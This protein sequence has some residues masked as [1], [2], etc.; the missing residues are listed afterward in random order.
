[1]NGL[2]AT[3]GG[4]PLAGRL[5]LLGAILV[6]TAPHLLRL[7]LWLSPLCLLLLGWR[8]GVELR[9][10]QLPGR[11]LRL[12]LTLL[13]IAAVVAGYRT[14]LGRDAGLALLT[15]MLCLKLLELRSQRDAM[16]ALSLGYFLVAGGFLYDQSLLVGA[17]LFFVVLILTAALVALNH[18]AGTLAHSRYYLRLGGS[19][20]LQALPIMLLLFVLFPRIPGPLWGLPKDAFAGKTGL[21]NHMTLDNITELADSDEVAFRVRFEGPMP[22]AAHLYWRGPVLWYTDGRRWDPLPNAPGN[23]WYRQVPTLQSLGTP[24]SYTVTQEPNNERWLFALDLPTQF[25]DGAW[26]SADYQLRLRRKLTS[27]QRYTLTSALQYRTGN[28]TAAER[29]A[30]LQLPPRVNPRSRELANEWRT[31]P[32]P[33][34]VQRALAY[35]RDQPFYYTRRPPP[36]GTNAMDDFLFSTRRGF[37][38]HYAAAFTML[39]RAAGVPARVVTGYQG[40]E[41]NPLSDYVIVRQSSAHAWS[42][43]YLPDS[44]WTRVD[45]TAVIPP[46]RV[47]QAYDLERFRSTTLQPLVTTRLAWLSRSWLRLRYSWDAL[48]NAWN[49]WVLGYDQSRQR[50][51]LERLGLLGF[52][53]QGV[54]GALVAAIALVLAAVAVFLLRQGRSAFVPA[55]HAYRKFTRRMAAIGLVRGPSEGVQTF[56]ERCRVARPDL[57]A[58]VEGITTLYIGLRYSRTAGPGDLGALQRAVNAFKPHR[59]K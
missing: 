6:V 37:C 50:Q 48:N 30:A 54:I 16:I 8:A 9:D 25:P 58:A 40:A 35:F 15:V 51:L 38:E 29:Q 19:L 55:V 45:P 42:E 57:D 1:M 59:S 33:Q 18:P 3:T 20:L 4:P 41:S 10:W 27:R 44:G 7:P 32:A 36:L 28:L 34:I 14:L 46:Q 43:V 12:G 2:A 22:P 17:Y 24:I 26:I 49:Q 13:G 21:S 5:W 31:L 23:P 47:E 52:G 11:W 53:W 39:M 56:A